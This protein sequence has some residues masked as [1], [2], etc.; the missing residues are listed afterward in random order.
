MILLKKN[1]MVDINCLERMHSN[2]WEPGQPI[3]LNTG[4]KNLEMTRLAREG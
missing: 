2:G 3:V 4:R 1:L